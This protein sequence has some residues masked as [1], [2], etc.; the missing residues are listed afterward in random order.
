MTKPRP[1]SRKATAD[2]Y[3]SQLVKTD[4][5]CNRCH[6]TQGPFEAAHIIERRWANTRCDLENGWC[7]CRL[8]HRLVDAAPELWIELVNKTI[9]PD[10]LKRLR[11][12]AMSRKKVDWDAVA[13]RLLAVKNGKGVS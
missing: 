3:W 13:L 4:Q 9:G 1:S 2:R 12:A 11:D 5:F 7:L 6:T 8:C 10:T